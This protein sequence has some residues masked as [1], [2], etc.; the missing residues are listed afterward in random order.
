[1]EEE[2]IHGFPVRSL[3]GDYED[4]NSGT[5]RY[6]AAIARFEDPEISHTGL[7]FASF[8]KVTIHSGDPHASPED[9]DR[10]DDEGGYEDDPP[11]RRNADFDRFR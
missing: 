6:D 2:R 7:V 3:D 10:C 8:T 4:G 1:M 11:P 5:G 9:V